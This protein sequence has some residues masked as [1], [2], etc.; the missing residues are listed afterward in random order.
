[1]K[2]EL[3]VDG[4]RLASKTGA[5]AGPLEAAL[6]AGGG[7]RQIVLVVEAAADGVS[8]VVGPVSLEPRAR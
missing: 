3:W 2:A 6:P 8:G 1:G 7:V 4:R 5:E